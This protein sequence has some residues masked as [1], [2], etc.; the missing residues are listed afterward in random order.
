VILLE[1]L[2]EILKYSFAGVSVAFLIGYLA[3]KIIIQV[4]DRNIESF[5][6]SMEKEVEK[7]KAE[8]LIQ[9]KQNEIKFSRLHEDRAFIIKELYKKIVK[10]EGMCRTFIN[11][12]KKLSPKAIDMIKDAVRIQVDL[13][14]YAEENKIVFNED[15]C[16]I[17]DDIETVYLL[18]G[19]PDYSHRTNAGLPPFDEES[20][21]QIEFMLNYNLPQLKKKLEVEFRSILG[22]I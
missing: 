22:V 9:T 3:N 4:L 11:E 20:I 5:K 13:L 6:I 12:L 16:K 1:Y 17:I 2:Q 10:T 7:Y 15:I 21:K 19:I 18:T 14:Q 8:L